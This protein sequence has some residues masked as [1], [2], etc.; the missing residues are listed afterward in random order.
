MPA[1]TE[2]DSVS[3][4]LLIIFYRYYIIHLIGSNEDNANHI[5]IYLLV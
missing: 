2:V 4:L 1:T 5:R 3:S